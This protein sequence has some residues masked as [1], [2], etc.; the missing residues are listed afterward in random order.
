MMCING[1][2]F[3]GIINLYSAQSMLYLGFVVLEHVNLAL[4]ANACNV[5]AYVLKAALLRHFNRNEE[6]QKLVAFAKEKCDPLDAQLMAEQWLAYKDANA[7]KTLISTLI[8]H[9][10][11]AEELPQDIPTAGFGM[12]AL[13]YYQN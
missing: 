13:L 5:R 1:N 2:G 9:P 6:A 4:D 8:N 12:M 7:A 11:N 3:Y 10:I